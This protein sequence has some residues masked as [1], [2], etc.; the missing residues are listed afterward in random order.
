MTN[1]L[2]TATDLGEG[3]DGGYNATNSVDTGVFQSAGGGNYYL[4]VDSPYRGVGTTNVDPA[5][6]ADL[7]TKTTWPPMVYDAV[8][9]SSLGTLA[10]Q[11]QR[12]T[13]SSPDIG[14]HYSALDY[15]IGGCDL[16]SNLTITAGTAIGFFFDYDTNYIDAITTSIGADSIT[17]N[18]GVDL[19]FNGTATQ[20]CIFTRDMMVQE[21][22]GP[23]VYEDSQLGFAPITFN[24]GD[25]SPVLSANFTKW[26]SDTI[27]G[28]VQDNLEPCAGSLMNCEFY[29]NG[30][31]AYGA[32]YLNFTNCLFFRAPIAFVDSKAAISFAFANC[33]FFNGG[34]TLDRS[35]V[36]DGLQS[37]FW[38]IENC[39]FDGTAF[40]WDDC[41]N[42][43]PTNTEFNYNAYNTN[44]LS[45]QTY[46]PWENSPFILGYVTSAYGT[47]EVVGPDDLMVAN[48]DWQTSSLGSFY[49]WSDSPLIQKGS[50]NANLLGLY[51]FT[52]QTDQTPEGTNIVDIGYHYVAT[53]Q[54]GDPLDSNRDGIPDYLEDANGDGLVDDGE[55]PWYYTIASGLSGTNGL[56][57]FTPLKP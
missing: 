35:D 19:S 14:Y 3:F 27:S 10:P 52:T 49:L 29:N 26:T 32:Q 56:L 40:D 21:G 57:V 16:Q 31:I 39:S 9:I 13:N 17:L 41:L 4:A 12:D 54:D 42:G 23:S 8:D 45:W 30:F 53:D 5:L 24:T 44:N 33:T 37:S 48:Y 55:S 11:A 6:L 34:L 7:S 51:H 15:L 25:P 1:C 28:Y 20:P 18:S 50:T 46:S 2:L 47:N 22:G 38:L 43:N 36:D